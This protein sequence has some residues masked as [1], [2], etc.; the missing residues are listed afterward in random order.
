MIVIGVSNTYIV[1]NLNMLSFQTIYD[2]IIKHSDKPLCV[3]MI[4]Y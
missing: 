2:R 4:V 3:F 1:I